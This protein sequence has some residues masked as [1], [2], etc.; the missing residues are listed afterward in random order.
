M[1]LSK[2]MQVIIQLYELCLKHTWF[3]N[4]HINK[5]N[6]YQGQPRMLKL[7]WGQEGITQNE[8][9]EVLE[10]SKPSVARTV[11]RLQK[12]GILFTKADA[13]D[14]QMVKI[15]LTP[16]GY[17]LREEATPIFEKI[18]INMLKGFTSEEKDEFINYIERIQKNIK[19]YGEI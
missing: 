4:R 11:K 16:R 7:L 10:I 18:A 2:D 15:Y 9:I 8:I 1:E 12:K 14:K 19:E 3:T 5:I 13:T 6:L 17:A